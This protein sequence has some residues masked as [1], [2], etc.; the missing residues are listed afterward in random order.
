[1]PAWSLGVPEP[2]QARRVRCAERMD[3]PGLPRAERAEALRGLERLNRWPGQR[4]PLLRAIQGLLG[5]PGPRR[6]LIELGAGSGHLSA[7]LQLQLQRRGQ[8]VEVL[9]T[10]RRSSRGVRRLDALARSLPEADVYFSNLLLHHLDDAELSRSLEAQA[11]ASRLGLAH[12]DLQRHWAH[13]YGAALL[14]PLASMPAIVREDGLRSI[15][16]GYHRSE[17]RA[18]ASRV[19]GARLSWH[20][21]CRWMLTWRR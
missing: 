6:R 2:Y 11:R 15:Q 4:G 16:Q 21:P 14:L 3:R 5:P 8:R 19:P 12:Y 20:F 7:W 1:M 10:D 13:Y 18:L 9:P 17:L